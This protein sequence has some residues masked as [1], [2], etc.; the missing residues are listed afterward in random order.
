[1]LSILGTGQ[2]QSDSSVLKTCNTNY[3]LIKEN[4]QFVMN[5]SKGYQLFLVAFSQQAVASIYNG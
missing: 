2:I 5:E 1:M 3:R 4:Y